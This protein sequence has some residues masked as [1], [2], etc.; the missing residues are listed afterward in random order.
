LNGIQAGNYSVTVT[1][2]GG[3]STSQNFSVVAPTPVGVTIGATLPLCAG[4]SASLQSTISGGASP[5]SYVW[6]NGAQTAA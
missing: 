6:S 1:D 4:G 5:Y 3:C 2:N